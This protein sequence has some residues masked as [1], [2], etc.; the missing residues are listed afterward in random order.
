MPK[1]ILCK[2]TVND[3]VIYCLFSINFDEPLLLLFGVHN[4]Y[5]CV[6]DVLSTVSCYYQTSNIDNK[7]VSVYYYSHSKVYPVLI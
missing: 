3:F 2:P 5:T 6:R 7:L 4:N 1:C